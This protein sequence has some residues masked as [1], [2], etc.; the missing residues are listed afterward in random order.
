M[1][2]K[3]AM[4]GLRSVEKYAA[5]VYNHPLHS[6]V[7]VVETIRMVAEATRGDAL[8]DVLN[9]LAKDYPHAA[10]AVLEL[11]AKEHAAIVERDRLK[12]ESHRG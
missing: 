1:S 10:K 11:L 6:H 3:P 12:T 7:E 9:M 4:L 5:L 8:L 2:D